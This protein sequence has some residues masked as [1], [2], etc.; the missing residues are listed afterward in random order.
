MAQ[1]QPPEGL[2]RGRTRPARRSPRK[3]FTQ[4]AVG[5]SR[6]ELCLKFAAAANLESHETEIKR[7]ADHCTGA[8]GFSL[9]ALAPNELRNASR[10]AVTVLAGPTSFKK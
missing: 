9:S 7:L 5:Q 10:A 6:R 3:A 8:S 2:Q 4:Q 1:K